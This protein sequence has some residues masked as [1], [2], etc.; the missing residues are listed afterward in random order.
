[1]LVLKFY[2]EW[3][4]LNFSVGEFFSGPFIICFCN[5]YLQIILDL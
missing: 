3:V 2:K 4:V 5:F 1:M